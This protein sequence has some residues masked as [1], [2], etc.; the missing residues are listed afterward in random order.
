M[1]FYIRKRNGSQF[2][3]GDCLAMEKQLDHA[4]S[5]VVGTAH[6]KVDRDLRDV[7]VIGIHI[8]GIDE[9][10]SDDYHEFMELIDINL[11]PY[12]ISLSII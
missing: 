1:K 2:H 12:H 5:K 11:G 10:A 8:S 6:V 7:K 3:D 4:I 9:W